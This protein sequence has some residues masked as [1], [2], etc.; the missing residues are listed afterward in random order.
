MPK[1]IKWHFIGH[2]QSN[3]AKSLLKIQNLH[4]IESL[5]SIKLAE[6]LQKI[7]LQ[8]KIPILNVFVQLKTSAEPSNYL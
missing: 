5:D 8:I 3:K 2:L 4:V 6:K 7:C 1:D